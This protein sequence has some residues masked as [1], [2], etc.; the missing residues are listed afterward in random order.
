M[1]RLYLFLF[2]FLSYMLHECC[3]IMRNFLCFFYIY[4]H[5][6]NIKRCTTY[7][8]YR[9][10]ILKGVFSFYCR[11]DMTYL[12]V[13]CTD[14]LSTVSLIVQHLIEQHHDKEIKFKLS[15][16]KLLRTL[17]FKKI[18]ELW[19]EQ[20]RT[21]TINKESEKIHVSK[22]N[23]AGVHK[24]LGEGSGSKGGGKRKSEVGKRGQGGGKRELATLLSTPLNY[25]RSVSFSSITIQ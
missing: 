2:L 25:L 6:T 24:I 11:E 14:K 18:P 15:E 17:N 5:L 1:F 10:I 13:Y 19:R 9:T 16:G 12:C 4:L 20:G 8:I 3:L 7:I 22:P 23:E 21:I